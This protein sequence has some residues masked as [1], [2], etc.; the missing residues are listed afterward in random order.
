M[1]IPSLGRGKKNRLRNL[2]Y[3]RVSNRCRFSAPHNIYKRAKR[4]KVIE[5]EPSRTMRE[6]RRKK[7]AAT[8]ILASAT[9]GMRVLKSL[10]RVNCQTHLRR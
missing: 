2:A 7:K 6:M 9:R 1:E 10:E 5:E 8:K 3:S 4:A